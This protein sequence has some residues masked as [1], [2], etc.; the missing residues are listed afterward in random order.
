MT[1][2]VS[3]AERATRVG[4]VGPGLMGLG[5]AEACAAAG[6]AVALIG[7]DL[8]AAAAGRDRLAASLRRRVER[9]RMDAARAAA[10]LAK[11]RAGRFDR[12]KG[13]PAAAIVIES[14][15]EDR[16]LK[17]AI[18]AKMELA[19]PGAIL[20]T[21]TSGLAIS[22][23]ATAL[24]RP[25]RFLGLH[26]FS[27]AERMP[28]VEVVRGNLTAP[29][30]VDA[31]LGFLR[32]ARQAAGACA[33]RARLFRDARVRRLSR[34]RRRDARRGRRARGRRGRGDRVRPRARPAGDARRNG[35]RAQSRAGAA[36]ACGR[37]RAALPPS[38]RRAGA[39]AS[40]RGGPGRT[41]RGRRLLRLAGG[42]A[43]HAVAGSGARLPAR[44]AATRPSANQLRLLAAEA[45]EALRC[46]E[47]GVVE[48]ADD[49]DAASVLG[50]G[51]PK[52][53]RR[54]SALGGGF[55]HRPS[56]RASSTPWPPSTASVSPVR[57]GCARSPRAARDCP[58]I[59][60]RRPAA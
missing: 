46:L 16:A 4:V 48:S 6:F 27:P 49:A 58:P 37:A 47:E 36:G 13:S 59:A 24:R 40:G 28:L 34:R 60:K 44:L 23:L 18:L 50:L 10:I 32:R 22:G 52:A 3:I 20:A 31:A 5:I 29:A 38:A 17:L 41:A 2:S 12:G 56:R 51:F 14:A 42:R 39:G 9:G 43:A 11:V 7:R 53:A 33:R 21:N 25:E 54:H 8:A 30:T 26:F 55:R 15:P 45:R 57:P 35:H 19:A 1:P